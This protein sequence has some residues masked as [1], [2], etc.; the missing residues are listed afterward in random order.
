[1]VACQVVVQFYVVHTT[2]AVAHTTRIKHTINET[3]NGHRLYM[4]SAGN[5]LCVGSK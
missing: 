2:A 5:A 4:Y 1:M 3:Q